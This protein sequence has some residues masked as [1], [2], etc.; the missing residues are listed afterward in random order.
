MRPSTWIAALAVTMALA[1]ASHAEEK[2]QEKKTA[3]ATFAGGCFWCMEPP[4]DFIKGVKRT[5]SGYTGGTTKN[6]TYEEVCTGKTGHA[7][8]VE[9][10]YDPNQVTYQQLLDVYWHNI[11]PTVSN[12][13]F[14]DSGTQY[15]TAIFYHDEEQK[16]LAEES[17][18]DVEKIFGTVEVQIVPAGP[19][20][21]A[22]E[23][24]QDFYMTNPDHYNAYHN[25]SG[26]DQR[27]KQLWGKDAPSSH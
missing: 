20:Y 7:E 12:R 16:R 11:D 9:I 17:K 18:K 15:R 14:V 3:V 27:L 21:P 5:T 13:Q 2:K 6:P 25:G 23:Y 8:A 1:V 26:R 10:E 22:E 4:Y 19:F 24:H